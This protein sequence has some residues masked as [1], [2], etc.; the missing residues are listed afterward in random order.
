MQKV[1]NIFNR[2]F[3]GSTCSFKEKYNIYCPGCGGT[4]SLKRFLQMEFFDSFCAN[5][6]VILIVLDFLMFIAISMYEKYR[7][8]GSKKFYRLR[9]KLLE[10]TLIIWMLFFVARNILLKYAGIDYLGDIL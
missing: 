3:E 1:I 10:I 7:L 8:K 5:P 2:I 4:R 6:W 9:A